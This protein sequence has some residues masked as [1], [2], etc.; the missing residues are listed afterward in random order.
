MY[1]GRSEGA[2]TL[3]KKALSLNPLSPSHFF[4]SLAAAYHLTAQ[5]NKAIAACCKAIQRSPE[6]LFAHIVLAAAYGSSGREEEARAE[7]AE[8]LRINPKFSTEYI[9]KTWPFKNKAD[10][11]RFV[12]PLHKAGLK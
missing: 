1:T 9:E 10:I 8:V 5:Y 7:A 11:A 3:Y 2:I 4:Q 12:E 6:S